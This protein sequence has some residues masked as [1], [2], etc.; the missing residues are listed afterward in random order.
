MT[1]D[2]VVGI[3]AGSAAERG[4]IPGTIGE[5]F[6]VFGQPYRAITDAQWAEARSIAM[7][8]HKAMNW[9]CGDAPRNRWDDSPT[10]T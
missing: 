4:D 1:L 2:D 10:D 9:L 6:P 3:A 8:R 5:D 7:E